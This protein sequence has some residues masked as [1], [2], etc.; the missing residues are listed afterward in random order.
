ML[1]FF[2]VFIDNPWQNLS[3]FDWLTQDDF[4]VF[5]LS[6]AYN[7]GRHKDIILKITI[8]D[9]YAKWKWEVYSNK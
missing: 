8:L 1:L 6:K 9:T 4:R 7:L 2:E 5:L 3:L